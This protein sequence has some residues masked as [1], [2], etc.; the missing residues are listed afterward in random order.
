M[1]LQLDIPDSIVQGI[2]RHYTGDDLKDDIA[3]AGRQ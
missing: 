2:P 3:Y 1:G